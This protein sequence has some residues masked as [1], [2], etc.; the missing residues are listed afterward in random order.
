MKAETK[1]KEVLTIIKMNLTE[2]AIE[3]GAM[4]LIESQII[5]YGGARVIDYTEF[6]VDNF[7]GKT[8]EPNFI[9][10]HWGNDN[11]PTDGN[12]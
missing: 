12:E 3:S 6:T 10:G 4:T 2:V 5:Q 8:C 7:I 1:L 11:K 9:L